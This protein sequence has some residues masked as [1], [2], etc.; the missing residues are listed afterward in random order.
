MFSE[1][2][3]FMKKRILA[4]ALALAML[5]PVFAVGSYAA[6]PEE[7]ARALLEQ[8]QAILGS[9]KFTLKARGSALPNSNKQVPI[10]FVV[11]GGRS[12]FEATM[13]WVAMFRAVNTNDFSST[14]YGWAM[15]LIFGK[16]V[17][18]I[19]ERDQSRLVFVNRR[20]YADIPKDPDDMMDPFLFIDVLFTGMDIPGWTDMSVSEPVIGGKKYLC[21]AL[22]GDGFTTA[23]YYL[24]GA[25]K[26]ITWSGGAEESVFE[27]DLLSPTVDES[28]FST[29][30][31][32]QLSI[33][34]GLLPF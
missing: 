13:D 5:L 16:K 29:K 12:M 1:S 8:T 3:F 11:D 33:L 22:E 2:G 26:R 7:Q 24:N 19:T 23:Y 6:T 15:Q 10:V 17:R 32:I 20:L 31:M 21:A 9:G 27:I 25:L 30:W 14:L 34:F 18:F 4:I 28:Y